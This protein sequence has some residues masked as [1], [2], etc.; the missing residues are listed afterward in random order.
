MHEHPSRIP[1]GR[2]SGSRWRSPALSVGDC[3]PRCSVVS[4]RPGPSGGTQAA[5]RILAYTAVREVL[6]GHVRPGDIP[7]GGDCLVI[8]APD[9]HH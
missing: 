3:W 8:V 4:G 2:S 1:K 5:A 6:H 9:A 7:V